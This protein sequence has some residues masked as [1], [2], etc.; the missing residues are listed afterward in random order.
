MTSGNLTSS[1]KPSD[2][3]TTVNTATTA[4]VALWTIYQTSISAVG[5]PTSGL[6]TSLLNNAGVSSTILSDTDTTLSNLQSN[7]T[8]SG[9]SSS[10]SASDVENWI[11]DAAGFSGTTTYAQVQTA[12]T[13]GW[14]IA[15]FKTASSLGYSTS[16]ADNTLFGEALGSSYT[17]HCRAEIDDDSASCSDLTK[18]QFNS[19]KSGSALLA[20]KKTKVTAGT[21][22][23][24]DLTELGLTTTALG[25]NPQQWQIDYLMT[26]LGT[27][28]SVTKADWQTTITAFNSS[29]AA[30]W[31]IAQIQSGASDHPT[32]DLSVSLLTGAG[33]SSSYTGISNIQT[34]LQGVITNATYTQSSDVTSASALDTW[35][36]GLINPS[37]ST[38]PATSFSKAEDTVDSTGDQIVL[39]PASV[40]STA[41]I[42]YTL[43]G[44][45]ASDFSVSGGTVTAAGTISPDTYSFT[46]TASTAY[47]TTSISRDFTLTVPDQVAQSSLSISTTYV[48]VS[49]SKT[50]A[51]SGGSGDGAISYTVTSGS[52]TVSG[53]TLTGAS[54]VGNCTVKATKASTLSYES[55]S[56]TKVIKV[57]T[58][59]AIN[60]SKKYTDGKCGSGWHTQEFAISGGQSPYHMVAAGWK[61]TQASNVPTGSGLS[62]YI[63]RAYSSGGLTTSQSSIKGIREFQR[64]SITGNKL[65]GRYRWTMN[66]NGSSSNNWINM[67]VEDAVGQ[68]KWFAWEL[69]C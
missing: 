34:L 46:V 58:T 20:T 47:S 3:E 39:T 22:V 36:A 55:T 52:C 66:Y 23:L 7:I 2:L 38:T 32:S 4:N 33:V 1:K 15:N 12:T 59:L 54:S 57:V 60:P 41:T 30:L 18:T 31:K 49:A 62:G 21:L 48:N 14:S 43:S 13:N 44:D 63:S 27:G 37:W 8:S 19:A 16:S 56:V 11:V 68:T 28:N 29:T 40:D 17:A 50:L 9:L 26:Q 67:K 6:T 25:S 51:T 61:V 24:S 69:D 35:I 45:D 5:Y 64:Q 10:L 65:K 53:S 42:T